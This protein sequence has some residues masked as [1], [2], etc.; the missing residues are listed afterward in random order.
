MQNKIIERDTTDKEP[1][2][3]LNPEIQSLRPWKPQK[4]QCLIFGCLALLSFVISLD[5]T[6]ITPALPVRKARSTTGTA[7]LTTG[8]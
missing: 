2:K 5:T 3:G 7:K 1:M 6:I 4:Q 8:H